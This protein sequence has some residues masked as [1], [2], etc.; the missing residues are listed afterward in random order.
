MKPEP[1]KNLPPDEL[2]KPASGGA[3]SFIHRLSKQ[4]NH[5]RLAVMSEDLF[6]GGANILTML[7]LEFCA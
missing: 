4:N 3:S 7:L 6:D 2:C 5:E 1:I